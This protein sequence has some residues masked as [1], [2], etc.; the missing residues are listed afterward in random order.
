VP[1]LDY[2]LFLV[3]N[4]SALQSACYHSETCQGC[5][6]SPI[7]RSSCFH[8]PRHANNIHHHGFLPHPILHGWTTIF[9]EPVFVSFSLSL[10]PHGC[11]YVT[12]FSYLSS[13]L[14]YCSDEG[15][16]P[17]IAAAFGDSAPTQTV[18]GLMLL[19]LVLYTGYTAPKPS[20]IGV[21]KWIS[22]INV[23]IQQSL[24]SS[25]VFTS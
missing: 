24:D 21:L 14:R 23:S 25:L 11:F 22:Y 18:P 17:L 6:V 4:T 3:R 16:V 2:H 1:C 12:Q 10:V 9:S 15:M 8:P 7:H 19:T 20:M 5:D 13:T